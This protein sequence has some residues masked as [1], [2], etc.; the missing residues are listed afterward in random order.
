M[1]EIETSGRAANGTGKNDPRAA[2]NWE[3]FRTPQPAPGGRAQHFPAFLARAGH[4]LL[5]SMIDYSGLADL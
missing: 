2:A 3:K 1:Q 4:P 5:P